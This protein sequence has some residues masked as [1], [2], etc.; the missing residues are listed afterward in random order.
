MS[1]GDEV[2]RP[3]GGA[4]RELLRAGPGPVDLA[5]IDP[6]STPGLPA[7]AGR[8]KAR[9]EWARGQVELLGAELGRQQE[10]LYASA[11]G[12]A[13]PGSATSAPTQAGAHL[14]GGRPR[15][16]LLVLQAMDCGGKDG[17]VKRVAGAMNPLGLHIRSFGPPTA[18]ERRH[19]FLWRIRRAL[20]PPGYV[21]V[22]NRSHYEDVLIARVEGLVDEATWRGRYDLINDFE[23]ELADNAVTVV[24]VMLHISREEQGERLME[25]LTD[26]TKYW[27][28]NPSDLDTRAR[29]DDYRAAYAEAIARCGP[30]DAPWFVVPADRKWYRDWAV[31]HLLRETFDG[32]D[33]GYPP[34]DFDLAR[35][36]DRL[37][38]EGGTGQGEQQVNER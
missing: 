19:D 37:R 35:E 26:P 7:A 6:R 30:D 27:K 8:G 29:W 2:V 23:R 15:R 10:M 13:G 33:L 11:K 4:M 14:A 5:A 1:G 28:Y 12:A 36:R 3:E 32:L 31:A 20:P 25:R 21:G 34:A 17:T 9:K 22:F 18:E 24:K 16:V 38:S